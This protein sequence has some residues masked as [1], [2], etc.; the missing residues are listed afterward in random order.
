MRLF[1]YV[2][3]EFVANLSRGEQVVLVT[4]VDQVKSLIKGDIA[5]GLDT[6]PTLNRLFPPGSTTDGEV[7]RD[8]AALT[9]QAMRD[10]KAERL[11]RLAESL[12]HQAVRLD[13]DQAREAVAAL[14]DI[15]LAVAEIAGIE[16]AADADRLLGGRAGEPTNEEDAYGEF[17]VALSALQESLVEALQ[18]SRR[19]G[20]H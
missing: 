4:V 11:T 7:A 17:Y 3:G 19:P 5:P 14:N 15:R 10:N 8:Y 12:G 2:D 13:R 6:Q 9:G 16:T 20:W 1:R 18:H